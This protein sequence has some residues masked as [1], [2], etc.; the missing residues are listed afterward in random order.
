M[1]H[2]ILCAFL[3]IAS[4]SFCQSTNQ[5]EAANQPAAAASTTASAPVQGH[6]LDQA[7]VDVLTGKNKPQNSY[8]PAPYY[9][10]GNAS[11]Y[12]GTWTMSGLG[13]HA[14]RS[15]IFS[16]R[17]SPFRVTGRRPFGPRF[18]FLF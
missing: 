11:L 7:D 9:Y 17:G 5:N 10:P 12:D 1:K 2:A 18:F 8:R 13:P 16:G 15:Q 4:A 6:P 14:F 3:L